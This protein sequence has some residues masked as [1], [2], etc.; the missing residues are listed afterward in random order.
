[1]ENERSSQALPKFAELVQKA[2]SKDRAF[3][4]VFVFLGGG[5][6]GWARE[7]GLYARCKL[8]FSKSTY[9]L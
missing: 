9:D 6:S 7:V 2:L 4:F 8:R 1:M 3:I 5:G